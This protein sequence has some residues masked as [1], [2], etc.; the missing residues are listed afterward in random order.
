MR[1]SEDKLATYLS[2]KRGQI[3][4][5]KSVICT[6]ARRKATCGTNQ[7]DSKKIDPAMR[8]DDEKLATYLPDKWGQI[9]FFK[10]TI[11]TGARRNPATC[12]NWSTRACSPFRVRAYHCEHRICLPGCSRSYDGN[13]QAQRMLVAR[14][15][16]TWDREFKL[17]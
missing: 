4:F 16:A 13:H 7:E 5:F 10:S 9:A 11:C 1:A 14:C 8:A 3:A 6:G 17:P 12:L 2:P 15:K